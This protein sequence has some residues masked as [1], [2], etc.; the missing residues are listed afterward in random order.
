VTLFAAAI[1]SVPVFFVVLFAA[2]APQY[3]AMFKGVV[4]R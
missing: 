1:V 4:N 2:F 3:L